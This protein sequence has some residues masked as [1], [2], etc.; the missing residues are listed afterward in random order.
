[1]QKLESRISLQFLRTLS[2]LEI[3]Q[4][5]PALRVIHLF[6]IFDDLTLIF[7]FVA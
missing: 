7:L 4:A 2:V 5:G 1:M 3:L 6:E